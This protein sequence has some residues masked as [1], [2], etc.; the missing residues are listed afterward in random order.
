MKKIQIVIEGRSEEQIQ[1]DIERMTKG[2]R[3]FF[4]EPSGAEFTF[5]N[6]FWG[7]KWDG[8]PE[9][10]KELIIEGDF[11]DGH[12]KH[13]IVKFML[14]GEDRFAFC[15][16]T[17]Q[18]YDFNTKKYYQLEGNKLAAKIT[19]VIIDALEEDYI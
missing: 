1:K 11:V 15:T 14:D 10:L 9:H 19:N 2:W 7:R 17:K 18:V 8:T 13:C 4:I 6:P 3:L 16:W 12:H 5:L